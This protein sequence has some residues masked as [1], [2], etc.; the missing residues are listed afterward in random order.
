MEPI[1]GNDILS[2]DAGTALNVLPCLT[3]P[4][5]SGLKAM[6]TLRSDP[7]QP[8][9]NT[10]GTSCTYCGV[11]CQPNLINPN[12]SLVNH[13]DSISM[14]AASNINTLATT[15][16]CERNCDDPGFLVLERKNNTNAIGKSD[17]LCTATFI[18]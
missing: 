11:N 17:E 13:S 6:C 12:H 9:L 15:F 5:R 16:N 18:K 3:H 7:V 4:T 2:Y 8:N 14:L 1:L 10:L